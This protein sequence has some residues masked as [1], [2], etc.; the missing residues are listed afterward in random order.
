MPDFG[1][2]LLQLIS[3]SIFPSMAIGLVMF[4]AYLIWQFLLLLY[5]AHPGKQKRYVLMKY[6]V[7]TSVAAEN[8]GINV[9]FRSKMVLC[10]KQS[11]PL[12][13]HLI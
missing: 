4:V 10:S 9:T 8:Y 5:K 6:K 11:S 1:F 3:L 2:G 12:W 13:R 7:N